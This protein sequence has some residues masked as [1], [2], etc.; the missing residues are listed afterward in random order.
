MMIAAHEIADRAVEAIKSLTVA[1]AA[2]D[3]LY[4]YNL[5]EHIVQRTIYKP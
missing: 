1:L 2:V 4:K 5:T 3:H